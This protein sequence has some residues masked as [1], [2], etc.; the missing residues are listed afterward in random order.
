MSGYIFQQLPIH[1]R[2]RLN[3]HDF[4]IPH[5]NNA[6]AGLVGDE[7]GALSGTEKSGCYAF[8]IRVVLRGFLSGGSFIIVFLL[9]G[10]VLCRCC[11]T[12]PNHQHRS[13]ILP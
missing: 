12:T 5:D 9:Q 3:F 6:G 2:V 11:Y 8:R 13:G 7:V 4:S 1:F 10:Q